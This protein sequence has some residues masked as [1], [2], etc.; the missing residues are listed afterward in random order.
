MLTVIG[1]VS[2]LK[3]TTS[4]SLALNKHVAEYLNHADFQGSHVQLLWGLQADSGKI[5]IFFL[6]LLK[7][8]RVI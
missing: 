5:Y 7:S 2:F 6:F 1:W 4:R 3:K 8:V